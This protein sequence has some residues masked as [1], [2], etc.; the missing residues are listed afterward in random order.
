MKPIDEDDFVP[1][2]RMPKTFFRASN[3]HL[4][5]ESFE[6]KW[7][8]AG[9]SPFRF[10]RSF[11]HAWHL[12]MADVARKK[13]PG[14]TCFCLGDPH[15]DNFGVI[16]FREGPRYVFNDLDDAGP[17]WAALDALRYFTGLRL[18]KVADPNDHLAL[19]EDIVHDRTHPRELPLHLVPS[20]VESDAKEL[21]KWTDGSRFRFDDSDVAL[22]PVD[23]MRSA[24]ILSALDEAARIEGMRILSV[25]E[26]R[27][28]DGG[29]GGLRRWLV[30]AE[31]E[32]E[33]LDL[34]ELKEMPLAAASW[35]QRLIEDD[36]RLDQA[37]RQIWRNLTPYH[38]REVKLG[39]RSF[40]LRSRLGRAKVKVDKIDGESRHAAIQTQVSILARQHRSAYR[41]ASV[42]AKD[43]DRWLKA[44][45]E[46]CRR[47][48]L[49][50]YE[51]CFD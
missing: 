11:A 47:R 2:K 40:L 18:S 48:I 45:V 28:A 3:A 51:R 21:A 33:R 30:L 14:G 49:A 46:A 15:P 4:D 17:G 1:A 44:S 5:E 37:V 16:S 10:F 34:L 8:S 23:P 31:D 20:V 32:R 13:I 42:D 24:Q 35:G 19:Y 7:S 50:L 22:A 39:R 9:K 26:R 29:S 6:K 41:S 38:H 25:A 36:D 12:E 27:V 43:L